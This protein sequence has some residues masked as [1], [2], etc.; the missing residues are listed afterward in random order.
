M[1]Y[2]ILE[3]STTFGRFFVLERIDVGTR[4]EARTLFGNITWRHI[5]SQF[6]AGEGWWR[7]IIS[8]FQGC[9][10]IAYKMRHQGRLV[11]EACRN[12][13]EQHTGR[14]GSKGRNIERRVLILYFYCKQLKCRE[15]CLINEA[16]SKMMN[17]FGNFH[18][19]LRCVCALIAS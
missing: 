13:H 3:H 17:C 10:E 14:A 5:I 19:N 1:S 16:N 8:R 9:F 4:C 6:H 12:R 11:L 18:E 7:P 15:L 2:D